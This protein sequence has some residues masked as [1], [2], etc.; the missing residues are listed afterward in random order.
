MAEIDIVDSTS[1]AIEIV[2]AVDETIMFPASASSSVSLDTGGNV[3]ADLVEEVS[4]D[5]ELGRT[6]AQGIPGETG[7]DGAPGTPGVDGIDGQ[8]GAPGANGVGVPTGG[9]AKQFLRKLSATDFDTEW[10]DTTYSQFVFDSTA[11]QDQ[12]VFNDWADLV[13]AINTG[14]SGQK[15]ITFR[16]N[17]DVLPAGTW[18]LRNTTFAGNGFPPAAGGV[19]IHLAD[20]FILEEVP[21]LKFES[22]IAFR[23]LS[24]NPIMT[25]TT[26]S[27]IFMKENTIFFSQN[28]PFFEVSPGA[29]CIIVHDKGALFADEGAPILDIGAS[30][31]VVSAI[32]GGAVDFQPDT[33]IGEASSYWQM[34]AYNDAPTS[35]IFAVFTTKLPRNT[36]HERLPSRRLCLIQQHNI[37]SRSNTSAVSDRR[38]SI[39][40]ETDRPIRIPSSKRRCHI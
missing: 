35:D 2:E 20:G 19:I 11:T 5:F 15:T 6:G 10:S 8:D 4:H 23:S 1:Q 13:E 39:R 16:N 27:S 25:I 3:E 12:N 26:L 24:N 36:R 22:F 14:Q 17:G 9:T 31:N 7:A 34:Y 30:G 37:R 38:G 32:V 40:H 18:S 28:S 29:F 33:V 21:S